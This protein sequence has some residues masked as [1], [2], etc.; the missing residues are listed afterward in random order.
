MQQCRP[1]SDADKRG[2][3]TGS[4]LFAY[5]NFYAKYN[6]NEYIHL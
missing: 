4:A 6:K 5:G 1:N 2:V 3:W